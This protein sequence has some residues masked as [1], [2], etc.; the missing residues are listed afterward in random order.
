MIDDDD[1]TTAEEKRS[2]ALVTAYEAG[3]RAKAKGKT[4][5]DNPYIMQAMRNAWDC[6]FGTD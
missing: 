2:E 4:A 5:D 1:D 3:E 6:G